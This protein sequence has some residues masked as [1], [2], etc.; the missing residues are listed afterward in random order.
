MTH[1]RYDRIGHGY[2]DTR[3]EDPALKARIREALGDV[4]SVVNVGAGAGSY[5]PDDIAVVAVEPSAVMVAQR[6]AGRPAVRGS[7]AAL[8]LHDASFDAAMTVLSIHHWE[9]AQERGVRELCRVA[10]DRVVIVTI[11]PKVSGR[12]WLM[13]DYLTEVRYLD[14]RILPDVQRVV[15]WLDRPATVEVVPVARDTPDWT[16]L[17]FWANP[18][19]VLDP[20]AR[21]ATSGFARQ[22]DAVVERVVR[23]VEADLASGRWDERY[24][25]LRE[26]EAFD[27]GLRLIIAER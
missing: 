18:E 24:G 8:P 15:D 12:M 23:D 10:R 5:E 4:R 16:L 26:L 3:R 17:S 11:D 9:P 25:H 7:A 27:G 13:A 21:F 19:R 6:P 14:H 20:A 22:T 1:P 2:A